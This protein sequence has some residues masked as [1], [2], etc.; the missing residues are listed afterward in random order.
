MVKKNVEVPQIWQGKLLMGQLVFL[1]EILADL[2]QPFS[3]EQ[4]VSA[5]G[6]CPVI[7][8]HVGDLSPAAASSEKTLELHI[9]ESIS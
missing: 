5:L 1:L 8:S 3:G 7:G 2:C 6:R 9:I 4:P